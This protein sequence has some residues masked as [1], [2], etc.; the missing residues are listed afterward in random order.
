MGPA[1]EKGGVADIRLKIFGEELNL[2]IKMS[3]KVPMG[4]VSVSSLDFNNFKNYI[5][6]LF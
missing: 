1:T 2:E 5:N 3:D 4:G 6:I